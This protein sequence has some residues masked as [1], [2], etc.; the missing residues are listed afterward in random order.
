MTPE[1]ELMQK[2]VF[3]DDAAMRRLIQGHRQQDQRRQ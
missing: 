1:Q 3:A 2:A